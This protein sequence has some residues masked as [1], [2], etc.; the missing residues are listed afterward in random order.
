MWAGLIIGLC[1]VLLIRHMSL[2]NQLWMTSNMVTA[3]LVVF[4]I[5][6]IIHGIVGGGV[7][8]VL[9]AAVGAGVVSAYL[10]YMRKQIGYWHTDAKGH[11]Q[12][13]RGKRDI[14]L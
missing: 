3:D 4:G 8:G 6:F 5:L 2:R 12:L 7:H 13:V 9:H 14:N 1:V 10:D 11:K